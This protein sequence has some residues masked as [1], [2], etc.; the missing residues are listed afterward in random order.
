MTDFIETCLRVAVVVSV[1]VNILLIYAIPT[2]E[3]LEQENLE[4]RQKVTSLIDF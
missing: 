1:V 3:K 4:L 2:D